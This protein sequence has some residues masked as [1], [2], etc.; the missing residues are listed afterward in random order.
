MNRLK[1]SNNEGF[2]KDCLEAFNILKTNIEYYGKDCKVIAVTSCR[3]KEGKS[4]AALQVATGLA[5]DGYRVILL[6]AD[7]RK[8]MVNGD[9]TLNGFFEVINGEVSFE[10]VLYETDIIGMHMVFAG[11]SADNHNDKIDQV[12]YEKVMDSLKDRYDFV[13]L[14][15]STVGKN[16]NDSTIYGKCDGAVLVMETNK[17]AKKL[18]SHVINAI[19]QTGCKVFGVVLNSK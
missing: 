2:S 3:D 10:D 7:F 13:I 1:I 18:A 8:T 15:T 11:G 17:V 9:K 19:E 16:I 14:D 5:N 12:T 6:L 4:L